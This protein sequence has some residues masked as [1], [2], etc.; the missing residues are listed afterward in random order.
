[1]SYTVYMCYRPSDQGRWG[2]GSSMNEDLFRAYQ[3]LALLGEKDEA[4]KE[5]K[6]LIA[7]Y[8]TEME[9]STRKDYEKRLTEAKDW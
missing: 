6:R 3:G 4:V 5:L 8:G 7:A 9:A 2:A 1:V